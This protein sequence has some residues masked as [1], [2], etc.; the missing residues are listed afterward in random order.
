MSKL[1]LLS[2]ATTLAATLL[3]SGSLGLAQDPPKPAEDDALERLLEKLEGPQADGDKPA[4]EK[5]SGGRPGDKDLDSLLEKLGGTT[6]APT[7]EDQPRRPGGPG[8]TPP[9]PPATRR[10]SQRNE[11]KGGGEGASTNTL[12]NS[13][14][15]PRRRIAK[16]S[17]VSQA[18]PLADVIKEMRNVEQRLG[19]TDTG[20]E[21]KKETGSDR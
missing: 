20:E 2:L 14:G 16:T 6:D 7:P 18:A 5:K 9:P 4:A 12:R 10:E 19:K 21:D 15:G 3:F 17:K 13:P 11:L 1:Q 8:Q